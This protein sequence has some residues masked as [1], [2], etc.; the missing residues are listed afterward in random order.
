LPEIIEAGL[1]GSKERFPFSPLISQADLQFFSEDEAF[2][3][4]VPEDS[5]HFEAHMKHLCRLYNQFRR[6]LTRNSSEA[7]IRR[8]VDDLF[9][10]AF[11][12]DVETIANSSYRWVSLSIIHK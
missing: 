9:S 3:Q 6:A 1:I 2:I 5:M 8:A 7:A 11:E 12:T 4:L 10:L